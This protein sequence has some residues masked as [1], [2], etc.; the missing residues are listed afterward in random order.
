MSLSSVVFCGTLDAQGTLR[1]ESIVRW[2][3]AGHIKP[4]TQ[5]RGMLGVHLLTEI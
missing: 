2:G 5:Q 4:G 1:I 3:D